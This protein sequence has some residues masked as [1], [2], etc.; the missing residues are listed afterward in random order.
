MSLLNDLANL[1]H[2]H[3]QQAPAKPA[4]KPADFTYN[5]NPNTN[6]PNSSHD[7]QAVQLYPGN[8]GVPVQGVEGYSP[9]NP[10]VPGQY[11][12]DTIQGNTYSLNPQNMP[13]S[14]YN[15]QMPSDF[16]PVVQGG[17]RIQAPG[18]S[19]AADPFGW[20]PNNNFRLKS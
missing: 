7:L 4:S 8:T 15:P 12:Q 14:G 13:G 10:A 9:Q 17:G 16:N 18:G 11:P 20:K 5:P 1:V 2:H 3:T 19:N 6:L